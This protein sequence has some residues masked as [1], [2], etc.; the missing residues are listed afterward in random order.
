MSDYN[1]HRIYQQPDQDPGASQPGERHS[2]AAPGYG[3]YAAPS[4]R[5]GREQLE[6]LI[7]L[8]YRRKWVILGCV[9]VSIA[10]AA[11]YTFR[12]EPVY[13]AQSYVLVDLEN[14]FSSD[15]NPAETDTNVFAR[16]PD[17]TL[18]GELLLLQIS[19][20]LQQRV[21]ERLQAAGKLLRRRR[22]SEADTTTVDGFVQ[23]SQQAGSKNIIRII[24]TS[25]RAA[26][27]ALLANLYA[28][29]YVRLTRDASRTYLSA[30]RESLE[31]KEQE[32]RAE[33]ARAEG[34]IQRF[35]TT[36]GA[37]GLDGD[38]IRVATQIGVLEAQRDETRIDLQTRQAALVSMEKEIESIDPQ[39]S[40][41]ASGVERQL[42]AVQEKIA[43]LELEK[44]QY[45]LDNPTW[46]N[47]EQESPALQPILQQIA[48]LK[49]EEKRLSDRYTQEVS[50]S[51]GFTGSESV[52][53]YLANLRQQAA[54]ERIQI[55]GLQARLD[56]LNRRLAE[57]QRE[58][59]QIPRQKMELTQ[60]ERTRAHAEQMYKYVVERL[61]EARIAEDSEPGYAQIIR[62][63]GKPLEPISPNKQRM[64]ILGALF[65]IFLGFGLAFML[66]K[67]DGRLYHPDQ[68]REMG[69]AE[70]GIIPDMHKLIRLEHKGRPF[71]EVDGH[72]YASSLVTLFNPLSAPSEAYRYVRTNVQFSLPHKVIETL[73][74]TS[75]SMGDG[76]TT[77]AANLAVVMAQAGRRTLLL[78][79]DLRR[80]N[81]HDVFGLAPHTGLAQ[82]LLGQATPDPAAWK[83]G[84]D[85]LYVLPATGG[86]AV[87]GA[88]ATRWV[89][90]ASE[91]LG[92]KRMR[93]LLAS[94]REHFDFIIIDSPPALVGTD[95]ALLSTQCDGT[96]VVVRAGKN[97]QKELAHTLEMLEGVGATLLGLLLNAFDTRRAYGQQ[98]RY[99]HYTRHGRYTK[100]GYHQARG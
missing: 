28:E 7:T 38:G 65:G 98:Y 17:R 68:L 12:Q 61:Q 51:G 48:Q 10:A 32:R 69:Y 35:M 46:R 21:Y 29:E 62:R 37:V 86:P 13:Q 75:A 99:Q 19:D 25:S 31:A 87:N 88:D 63:A 95:A 97:D 50:D 94:L 9:V 92:S 36:E 91:L 52:A 60:L 26:D 30:L 6:A 71:V 93:E 41:R 66:T 4:A 56:V 22:E 74:V 89:E 42:Q 49:T 73:L 14:K 27:A 11:A 23:P 83:T 85:H 77:A 15:E 24:G 79:A 47:R 57:Y 43:N 2:Y 40:I 82:L 55:G 64:L 5:S 81:Q 70:I 100:Y 39:S 53:T 3:Y 67:F 34:A 16:N 58:L 45:L 84:I 78:D 90:N 44:S 54:Q 1:R 76:K 33:L 20:Q 72:R 80:P 59:S 8:L 18:A 96:I